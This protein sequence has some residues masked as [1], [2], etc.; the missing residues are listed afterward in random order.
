MNLHEITAFIDEED[1]EEEL[2]LTCPDCEGTRFE[3]EIAG[4]WDRREMYEIGDTFT[5]YSDTNEETSE[6][7]AWEC[8][9]CGYIVPDGPLLDE[10]NRHT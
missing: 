5:D 10:I 4:Y 8:Q 1:E 2:A 6:W 3:R 9:G 7:G